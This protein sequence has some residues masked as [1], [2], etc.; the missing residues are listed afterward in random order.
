[1]AKA[2]KE[3]VAEPAKRTARGRQPKAVEEAA[4]TRTEI[5]D[6][7]TAQ[8][9]LHGLSGSRVDEIADLT[10]TSKRMIYYHFKS[11]EGLYRAVLERLYEGIRSMDSQI[12]IEKL[13]PRDAIRRIVEITFDH[14]ADD[15]DFVRLVMVE[16]IHQ[17]K[18]L[19]RLPKVRRRNAEV[20]IL[21]QHILDR[22][23]AEGVFRRDVTALNLHLLISG[24]CFFRMSN[25]YTF[26]CLFD[27][28]LT[29]P[30]ARK[31]HRAMMCDVVDRYLA[32]A[33]PH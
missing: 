12:D 3:V 5:L 18:S 33:S 29:A 25:R 10:R 7:A 20:I 19:A 31:E 9:A 16:N 26:G 8:F 30:A 22:G 14:H 17:A 23:Q 27:C 13:S 11:K 21:L 1:M 28:D 24:L 4:D 15:P 6:V 2:R 32:A